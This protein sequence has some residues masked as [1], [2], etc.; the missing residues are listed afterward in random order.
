MQFKEARFKWQTSKDSVEE[1][2][3]SKYG[4]AVG[5]SVWSVFNR[6]MENKGPTC[7]QTQIWQEKCQIKQL[8]PSTCSKSALIFVVAQSCVRKREGA[9]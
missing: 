1:G 4:P 3:G 7:W 8:V 9:M 2:V 5:K 6:W